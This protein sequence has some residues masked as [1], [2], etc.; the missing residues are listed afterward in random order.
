MKPLSFQLH[1]FA[2]II[3]LCVTLSSS[4][5]AHTIRV[6]SLNP[7]RSVNSTLHYQ[8]LPVPAG[9]LIQV[10]KPDP[11]GVLNPPENNGYVSRHNRLVGSYAMGD[12]AAGDGNF[13][14]SLFG[15]N[16]YTKFLY[17][18]DNDG[19]NIRFVTGDTLDGPVH[20]NTYFT[21]DG[22]PAFLSAIS[23]SGVYS[24]SSPYNR[25]STSTDPYFAVTPVWGGATIYLPAT[26]DSFRTAAQN[27]GIVYTNQ[28]LY[29][30]FNEDGTYSTKTTS[31]GSWIVHTRPWNGIIFVG[32][33]DGTSTTYTGYVQG[34]VR[35]SYTLACQGN[36]NITG[37]LVYS[38]D[39]SNSNSTDILALVAQLNVALTNS[40]ADSDRTIMSF[41][42]TIN[43][44]AVNNTSNF[45]NSQYTSVKSGYLHLYGGLAMRKR[46]AMGQGT[47]STRTGYLKDYHYDTRLYQL[48]PPGFTN[49]SLTSPYLSSDQ[50]FYLRCWADVPLSGVFQ[51]NSHYTDIG[52]FTF[53]MAN[54]YSIDL[55]T[56]VWHNLKGI[57]LINTH[58]GDTLIIGTST[59]I[60]WSADTLIPRVNILLN[61]HYPVGTWDTIATHISSTTSYC[62]WQVIGES[63]NEARIRIESADDPSVFDMSR[64]NFLIQPMLTL[65]NLQG[66]DSISVGNTIIFFW[67]AP[68]YVNHFHVL[69]NRHYPESTWDT[70]AANYS[71]NT[72]GPFTWQVVGELTNSARFRIEWANNPLVYDMSSSNIV[73]RCS[74]PAPPGNLTISLHDN[75]AILNWDRVDTTILGDPVYVYGYGIYYRFQSDEGWRYLDFVDAPTLTFILVG[76][77]QLDSAMYYRVKAYV[78][79]MSSDSFE[80]IRQT[81]PVDPLKLENTHGRQSD[82]IRRK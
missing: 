56:P 72:S 12:S 33:A 66:G 39:P 28:T 52:P 57:N 3:F 9:N 23:S 41:I 17:L 82:P 81:I 36:I 26:V 47:G 58:S 19:S 38:T 62:T 27:G 48:V 42:M 73:I 80:R 20:T 77:V 43:E 63:T 64:N 31:T 29:V 51:P 15:H 7:D 6:S 61:R 55:T 8:G 54:L 35:G 16:T 50:Q 30:Q 21:M 40:V 14:F 71:Y 11:D 69:L 1:R 49:D 37:N 45:Y 13:D 79:Q 34:V 76:A 32:P 5:S 24:S 75:D 18:T 44:S 10:I 25:Y 59:N 4:L 22:R 67:D 60:Y 78:T 53:G 74:T 65:M 70:L 68:T 2:M 46:G